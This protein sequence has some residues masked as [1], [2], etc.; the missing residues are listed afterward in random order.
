MLLNI[1]SG[2]VDRGT[3]AGGG[4]IP[5]GLYVRKYISMRRSLRM[6]SEIE[7][8]KRGLYGLVFEENNICRKR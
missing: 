3:D 7:Y 8:F 4:K 5:E 1:L 6:V 2:G